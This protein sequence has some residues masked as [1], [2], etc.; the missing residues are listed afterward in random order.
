[1]GENEKLPLNG[2]NLNVRKPLDGLMS[3]HLSQLNS[4]FTV[5]P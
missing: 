2:E 3:E 5:L 4:R 1:M